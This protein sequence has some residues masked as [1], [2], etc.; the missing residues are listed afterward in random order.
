L[1]SLEPNVDR[2]LEKHGLKGVVGGAPKVEEKPEEKAEV[3]KAPVI[4]AYKEAL[5]PVLKGGRTRR[6]SRKARR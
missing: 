1:E 6:K 5:A 3:E 4:E 2:L